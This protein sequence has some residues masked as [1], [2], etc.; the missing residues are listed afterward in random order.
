MAAGLPRAATGRLHH[1]AVPATDHHV[2][3][4]REQSTDLAGLPVR[5]LV[6]PAPADDADSHTESDD[7]SEETAVGA[8]NTLERISHQFQKI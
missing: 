6:D 7:R 8:R 2:V 4:F 3:A 5:L 1:P